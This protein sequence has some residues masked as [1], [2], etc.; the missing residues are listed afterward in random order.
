[1][2]GILGLIAMIA[3]PPVAIMSWISPTSGLSLSVYL[4]QSILLS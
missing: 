3:R 2:L 4:D 1:M